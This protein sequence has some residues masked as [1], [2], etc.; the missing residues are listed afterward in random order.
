MQPQGLESRHQAELKSLRDTHAARMETTTKKWVLVFML[1][2]CVNQ[3]CT[4]PMVHFRPARTLSLLLFLMPELQKL[5]L[6][7]RGSKSIGRAHKYMVT[8]LFALA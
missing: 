3:R 8:M 7:V 6:S 4:S 5:C 1:P 2:C